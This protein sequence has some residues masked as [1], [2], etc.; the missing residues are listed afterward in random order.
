MAGFLD[1]LHQNAKVLGTQ[2]QSD[3]IEVE[4]IVDEVLY[5]KLAAYR[6]E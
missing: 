6:K 3:G 1:T 5:G 2:Y 4:A